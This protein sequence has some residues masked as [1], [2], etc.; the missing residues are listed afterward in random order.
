MPAASGECLPKVL[1]LLE[2]Q[3]TTECQPDE[4]KKIYLGRRCVLISP[5]RL[6]LSQRSGCPDADKPAVCNNEGQGGLYMRAGGGW[7]HTSA[8]GLAL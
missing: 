7:K 3:L 4:Y 5:S 2:P 1:V 6:H 8:K